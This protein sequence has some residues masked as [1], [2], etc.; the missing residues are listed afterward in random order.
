MVWFCGHKST[1]IESGLVWKISAVYERRPD[2]RVLKPQKSHLR[3]RHRFEQKQ[4]SAVTFGGLAAELNRRSRDFRVKYQSLSD[5]HKLSLSRKNSNFFSLKVR[6]LLFRLD[7]TPRGMCFSPLNYY[8]HY[9][10]TLFP[11]KPKFS[12]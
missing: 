9:Y 11:L 1:A 6:L 8:L 7:S 3:K 2:R 5:E 4:H 10:S 12:I